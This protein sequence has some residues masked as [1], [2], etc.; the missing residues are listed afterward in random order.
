MDGYALSPG[1]RAQDPPLSNVYG[2]LITAVTTE[3]AM[4]PGS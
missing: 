1:G 3:I 4:K 2:A